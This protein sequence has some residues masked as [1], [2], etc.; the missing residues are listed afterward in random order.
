LWGERLDNS[1]Q[2]RLERLYRYQIV[3]IV[4]LRSFGTLE[5]ECLHDKN[6]GLKML[7]FGE[8]HESSGARV[9]SKIEE[10][11]VADRKGSSI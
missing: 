10:N 7:G 1:Y 9:T 6:C 3:C 4:V 11:F 5:E 2:R 8:E